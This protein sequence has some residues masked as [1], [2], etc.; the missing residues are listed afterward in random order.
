LRGVCQQTGLAPKVFHG[1]FS[2][3]WNL[4]WKGQSGVRK[5]FATRLTALLVSI[6]LIFALSCTRKGHPIHT[7][8][9]QEKLQDIKVGDTVKIT[10]YSGERYKFKVE[11]I[12]HEEIEGQGHKIAIAE[13]ENIEKV[14][15]T[16]ERIAAAIGIIALLVLLVWLGSNSESQGDQRYTGQ[17]AN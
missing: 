2:G 14:Y 7:T 4:V 5:N 15:F 8:L 1:I 9:P 11:N 16:G 17:D 12:T 10:T 13:I 6:S 3:H